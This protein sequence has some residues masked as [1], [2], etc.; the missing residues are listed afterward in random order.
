M[1]K[2]NIAIING[3][4]LPIS[5]KASIEICNFIKHKSLNLARDQL[6]LVLKKKLAIPLKR[7]H[8]DR[9]HRAGSIGPGFYPE[10]PTKEII[11]LLNSVEANAQN[12]GLN[13]DLLLLK[14]IIVNKASTPSHSG[15][16][17]GL[18]KRTHIHIEVEEMEVKSTKKPDQKKEIK[19]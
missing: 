17:R 1:E 4:N 7:F 12:N 19:K 16:N 14:N 11:K 3:L 13:T 9:G 10:K 8:K 6:N 18:K 15:R 2:S 5:T